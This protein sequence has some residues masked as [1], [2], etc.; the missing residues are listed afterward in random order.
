MNPAALSVYGGV[1]AALLAAALGFPMPEELPI[2]AAGALLGRSAG[3]PDAPLRWWLLL[4]VCVLGV[5]LGDLLLYAAGRLGG[6][7]VLRWRPVARALPPERLERLERGFARRGVWILLL[8]R[9][10]PGFRSPVFLAAGILRMPWRR[11]LLADGLYALPG[12]S[13]LF[14][15][16][17][18]FTDEFRDWVARAEECVYRSRG[19]LLAGLAAAAAA[20]ALCRRRRVRG[21]ARR[22]NPASRSPARKGCG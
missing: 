12:V 11:F 3:D 2:V 1:F 16:A 9:L 13:L 14:F 18:R 8:A 4:P 22:V 21:H 19:P 6:R 17:Y 20:Y 10:T 5:V 7:R 15:L